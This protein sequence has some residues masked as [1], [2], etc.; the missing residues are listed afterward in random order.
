MRKPQRR[1][2][3][4][5]TAVT[6]IRGG[7]IE[8]A[9]DIAD[10]PPAALRQEF[11]GTHS[12]LFVIGTDKRQADAVKAAVDQNDR[13][14]NAG[15]TF[16]APS[17]ARDKQHAV[18]PV[19]LQ[20]GDAAEKKMR[21]IFRISGNDQIVA[22]FL[23][24]LLNAA[25]HIEK[26]AIGGVIWLRGRDDERDHIGALRFKRLC[27]AVGAVAG[28]SDCIADERHT[29]L[30]DSA[31]PIERMRN[32]GDRQPGHTGDFLQPHKKLLYSKRQ[33]HEIDKTFARK[34]FT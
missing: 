3:L 17:A 10:A 20:D 21:V 23:Q 30:R 15:Q 18:N 11:Y 5:I 22:L 12:G 8:R 29:L 6:V 25:K 1:K 24:R 13:D 16:G 34:R 9:P 14:I 2:R 28:F 32:G 31:R 27:G 26:K 7:K 33:L 4:L 19:L